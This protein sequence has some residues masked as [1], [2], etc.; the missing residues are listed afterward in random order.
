MSQMRTGNAL[1]DP[2]SHADV[3]PQDP[4]CR[5]PVKNQIR[6][7]QFDDLIEPMQGHDREE[8][9]KYVGRDQNRQQNEADDRDN[10]QRKQ[11]RP[12]GK[13]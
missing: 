7:K 5:R 9:D 1:F 12:I 3:T 4:Q 10:F 2:V 8:T 6:V 11:N 13:Q